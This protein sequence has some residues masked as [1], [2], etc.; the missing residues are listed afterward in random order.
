MN[1][2]KISSLIMA[3]LVST[4]VLAGCSSNKLSN[5]NTNPSGSSNSAS[6]A[7][8]VVSSFIV[9]S[10]MITYDKED[11]YTDWKAEN[12]NYIELNGSSV[13]LK[14]SGA[15]V[16]GSKITITAA[17]VY[18]VSGKLDNGQII[19]DVKD[20]GTVKLVLNGADISS[21]DS[22]PIYVKNAGKAIISLE[23][24]T[25]NII[26]D[27]DKYVLEDASD[28]EPN[29]AIFSKADLIINGTGSLIVH[30]NYNNGIQSKD[31]LKITAGNITV[32][33]KDDGLLGKDMLVVK[34]GNIKI[35]AGG[36][37]LKSTNDTEESKGFVGLQGGTFEI[38]SGADG[39][40]AATS[41]LIAGG[42]YTIVTG[43]G[44][45]NAPQKAN[46]E[47][48]GGRGFMGDPAQ[49]NNATGNANTSTSANTE[50]NESKSAKAL[51]A[52]SDISISSG[53]FTIDSYDDS[54]HSN[55]TISIAGGDISL[56]SGDDGIHADTSVTIKDGKINIAKSYE[57]V[58]SSLITFDGGEANI[59]A[60]DDGVNVSGGADGS[61]VNGRPG[62][63][64]FNSSSDRKLV[65]NGGYI[66]VN[67]QGDGLDSNGSMYM[68]GGTVVVSGPTAN[69]NG[70]LDYDGEFILKG[71]FLVAA[72][73]SGMA[74]A[75]TDTS[76]Q[77]SIAMSFSSTQEAGKM[78]ALKDSQGNTITAFAPAKQYQTVV[79]T[80]PEL[81][82]DGEYTIYSGG[83]STGTAV[84]GLYKDGEYKDGTKVV[85]FKTA[86]VTT[87]LNESGVTTAR[88]GGPGG[89]GGQK[90]FGGKGNRMAPGDKGA[91]RPP[92]APQA[93]Q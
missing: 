33:A 59:T 52:A 11:Y 45:A 69:N 39:I 8:K 34:D 65:I 56:T 61:S 90:G 58:E 38:K 78:I 44:S 10:D 76:A 71:G 18:A 37:G 15:E 29:A 31:D 4:S 82:K 80:S 64:N 9:T 24:G 20:K 13:S 84:N 72:G 28:N 46:E 68:N 63:N 41:M 51:K 2:K 21:S 5:T 93:P 3:L 6:E 79:I 60:S 36:D 47:G 49:N 16:K 81:K 17:G 77:Y 7:S 30:G 48:P 42:K 19:I 32:Y 62:Q 50:Q 75:P 12:P 57:G 14:G 35:E 70:A 88:S 66:A 91:Q 23:Q 92:Q 25:Q 86:T 83:S 55:N 74:Q 89:P 85:S 53:S 54:L 27:G 73:S 22:A 40:Q 43:G 1:R 67:S 87:W 26:K